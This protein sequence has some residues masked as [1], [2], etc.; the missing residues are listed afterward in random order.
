MKRPIFFSFVM[1]CALQ[2]SFFA[3]SDKKSP[4][5]SDAT[6]GFTYD[7]DKTNELIV[8]RLSDPNTSNQDVQILIEEK[9]FPKLGKGE[10]L[11]LNYRKKIAVWVEKNPNLIISTLKNRK[12][13]VQAY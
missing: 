3:Q 12:N 7:F 4:P 8:E 13:I 1:V 2:F 10:T 9:S 6:I 11:D 5:P